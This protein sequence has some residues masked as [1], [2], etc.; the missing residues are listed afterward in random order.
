MKFVLGLTQLGLGFAVIV[1]GAKFFGTDG[2]VP[3]VFIFFMYLLHT[4][5]ELSLSPVGLSM[6]TKLSPGKIVGF[7]MGAWF[8]SIALAVSGHGILAAGDAPRILRQSQLVAY[9]ITCR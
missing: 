8:L 3:V 9:K 5:G 6:I 4:T 2:L 7:V 1:V